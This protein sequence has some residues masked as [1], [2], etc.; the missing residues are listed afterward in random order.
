MKL[1]KKRRQ[2]TGISTASLP[3]IIFMILFFFM[4]VALIPAPLPKLNADVP[5]LEGGVELDETARYI[6]VYIGTQDGELKA[7]VG[8]NTIV[9]LNALTE[10]LK[11]VEDG[12]TVV[13][14]VDGDTGMGFVR[15]EIEPAILDAGI[16]NI[17]Y[18]LEDE[19]DKN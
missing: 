6:H 1:R 2:E 10:A 4:V 11:D 19:K 3:D 15:N 12:D 7:Q 5:V 8:Y 17:K 9:G 16:K 18:Q 14:R 13:L